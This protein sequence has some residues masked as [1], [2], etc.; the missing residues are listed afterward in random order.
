MN[1][2]ERFNLCNTVTSVR[3]AQ[4]LI[5]NHPEIVKDEIS[6]IC[7]TN[8]AQAGDLELV[9]CLH[10]NGF[11]IR[12]NIAGVLFC[13]N[14]M[15]NVECVKCVKYLVP[16]SII[17]NESYLS[18]LIS[19]LNPEDKLDLIYMFKQHANTRP[20]FWCYFYAMCSQMDLLEVLNADSICYINPMFAEDPLYYLENYNEI[21]FSL[22]SKQLYGEE[23]T[24][25]DS[26]SYLNALLTE[27]DEFTLCTLKT[28][29]KI[30]LA[31]FLS[32][33]SN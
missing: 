33:R 32:R 7:I 20:N 26:E 10:F 2:E 28:F 4:D 18:V 11:P 29:R 16:F 22:S 12:K 23:I 27:T 21:K 13:N 31:D 15:E 3:Q 14:A 6:D 19:T 9:K 8:A 17:T 25:Y 24:A 5:A 1:F 30:D